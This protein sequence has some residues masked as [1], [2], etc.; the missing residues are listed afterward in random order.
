VRGGYFSSFLG[1]MTRANYWAFSEEYLRIFSRDRYERKLPPQDETIIDLAAVLRAVWDAEGSFTMAAVGCGW[2]RWLVNGAAAARQ[3]GVPFFLIGVEAEPTHFQWMLEHFSDNDIDP[4]AH[5]LLEAAAAKGAGETWF[6]QGDPSAWYGQAMVREDS[7]TPALTPSGEP[8]YLGKP[9]RRVPTIGLAEIGHYSSK[10]DYLH[11]DIQ[12]A[13]L[14][15]LSGDLT[16][17]DRKVKRV[18]VGAHSPEIEKGLR[19][20]FRDLGWHCEHDYPMNSS[21]RVGEIE[22]NVGDGEQAWV[23]PRSLS[24]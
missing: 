20:L 18:L 23:N 15:F 11:M 8:T 17:L 22:I 2:G 24:S 13:E 9:V 12:G 14:D 3:R 5:V 19:S 21:V 4:T 10:I 7:L 1:T 6:C 16:T